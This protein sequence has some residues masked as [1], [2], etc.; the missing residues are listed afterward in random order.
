MLHSL[1]TILHI[2][3]VIYY[4]TILHC[5]CTCTATTVIYYCTALYCYCHILLHCT[6]LLQLSSTSALHCIC[7]CTATTVIYYCTVLHCTVHVLLVLSSTTALDF[8]VLYM[9]CLCCHLLLHWTSL[10]NS[11]LKMN[12]SG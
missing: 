3:T 6:V 11:A 1:H 7:T 8:T 5:T 10:H 9:Y 2:H 12:H 4:C